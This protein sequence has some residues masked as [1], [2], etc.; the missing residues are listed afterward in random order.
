[1]RVAY[2]SCVLLVMLCA[3]SAHAQHAGA[4]ARMGFGARGIAMGNATIADMSGYASPYYN[5]ALAP[6]LASQSIDVSAALMTLDRQLQFVQ[7]SSPLRP[8]AGIA[9]GLIHAGVSNFDGRDANGYHT[10]RFAVNEYGFFLA[11]GLNVNSRLSV[12][13]GLELFRSDLFENVTAARSFGLD[14]GLTFRVA[15][16]IRIGVVAD[17]LL[18]SYSWDTSRHHSNGGTTRDNFPRR[19]RMGASWNRSRLRLSA[20]Y[21]S[22][23]TTSETWRRT[24]ELSGGAPRERIVAK[25]LTLH[26]SRFRAGGEY[27]VVA[28]FA[29]RAGI[30]SVGRV[31]AMRPSAGFMVEQPLGAVTVHAEYAFVLESHAL[32]TIHLVTLRFY[33]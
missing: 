25:D 2:T 16:D 11:F 10:G 31:A 33:L 1:M 5:P 28:P 7:L 22:R 32:G 14:L 24:V 26:E 6:F 27:Q 20:E 8:R 15:D 23:L 12:G 21:E 19:Y 13:V 30:T 4:F 3:V 17:D 29:A 18:A 9:G